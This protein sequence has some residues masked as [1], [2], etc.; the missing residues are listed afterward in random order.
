MDTGQSKVLKLRLDRLKHEN[1]TLKEKL[2][3]VRKEKQVLE[4]QFRDN[5]NVFSE[6]P[7]AVALIQREKVVQ[8]N[9]T[10]LKQLGYQDIEVLG[11]VYY[12]FVHFDSREQER[13][14]HQKRISGKPVPDQYEI[15]L[16][17]RSGEALCCEM[18]AKKIRYHGRTAFLFNII[19]L[20][21]RNQKEI[22]LRRVQK[23]EALNRMASYFTQEAAC[24]LDILTDHSQHL[25]GLESISDSDLAESLKR[26]EAV[27]ERGSFIIQ[28]LESLTRTQPGIANAEAIDLKKI[29]QDAVALTK[30]KWKDDPESRGVEINVKTYLRQLSTIQGHLKEIQDVI[31]IM[32]LN[33]VYALPDGGD[34]YLTTE[35]NSGLAYFYIQDN[36]M[37]ISTDIKDKIFDPFFTTEDGARMGLGLSL[38]HAIIKRHGGSIDVISQEGQGSMFI[39]KLPIDSKPSSS[40]IIGARKE[41]NR[42]H[43]LIIA[44][45][46]FVQDLLS[47]VFINK[48]GK[49]IVVSTGKEGLKLLK[50]NRFD[51]IMA[52]LNTPYLQPL[53]IVPKIREMNYGLPIILF[54]NEENS[55]VTHALKKSGVDLIMNRPLNIDSILAFMPKIMAKERT[56]ERP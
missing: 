46:G 26:I 14:L 28:Q 47:Q 37:G 13:H 17:A 54:N 15:Y 23:T 56:H 42:S 33:A 19:G 29:V 45:V 48:G 53:K 21:N 38:A 12:D 7:G 4:K 41:I 55:D 11:Q 52:D 5:Y 18:Q 9:E 49:V 40:K 32:I 30:P 31:I 10:A 8:I 6:F 1:Q 50:K 44:D 34:I 16:M 22:Q 25:Q 20:D 3:A 51:L 2:A 39:L 36:G 24:C 35:E 27:F 43:I